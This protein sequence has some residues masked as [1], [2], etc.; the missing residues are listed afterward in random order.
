LNTLFAYSLSPS[1]ALG[2]LGLLLAL[3][4]A[5]L[6]F[7]L[8]L[9][10]GLSGDVRLAEGGRRSAWAVF[11]FTTLAVLVLEVA[12]VRNDFSLR[13]VADHSTTLTP[14]WVKLVTLWSALA[15]SVLFWA[16]VLSLY[17]FLL[18][19]VA[20]NDVLRPWVM[21]T[22]LFNLLFF[23]GI[24]LTAV[25][26]FTA[27]PL[28]PSQGAGPNPLL[29]NNAMMAV[30]PVLMYLGYVGLSVPFAYAVAA[31]ASG[32]LGESWLVQTRRW[33]L[34][35]WMFLSAAL[36]AGAFWSYEVLGWGGYWAWDPVENAAFFPWLFTTAYLHSLQIQERRRMLK[37]WNVWLIIAAYCSTLLGTFLTRSGVV[38]SVHS[39]AAGPS[40]PL[41]LVFFGVSTLGGVILASW[42]LSSLRDPR[43]IE[44]VLSR[45]SAFLAGNLVFVAFALMV[46]GGT[47]FPILV[48]VLTGAQSSVGAPFYDFFAI[49]LGLLLLALMGLGPLLPWNRQAKVWP[50]LRWPLAAFLA[51]LVLIWALGVHHL[52]PALTVGLA[53]FNLAGLIQLTSQAARQRG[54][55]AALPGLVR[56]YPRRYGAYLAHLGLVIVALG[57]AFSGSYQRQQ[58]ATISRGQTAQLLGTPV[59]FLGLSQRQDPQ[60]QSVVAH[61]VAG[62][63]AMNP[64][65]R[66]YGNAPTDPVATPE[67]YF[68]PVV[69]RY[70]TLLA[71]S[72]QGNWVTVRL[73][74]TPLVS[75]IWVGTLIL[76]LGTGTT[77][78]S[79]KAREL[80]SQAASHLAREGA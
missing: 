34:L 64:A 40:G 19:L 57:L 7:L 20:R 48:G 1:S 18:S 38:E 46:I 31:L 26:P 29:Q 39:F 67:V 78:I 52:G 27:M 33:T 49:P 71:Y 2:S 53:G 35:S 14:L 60:R 54:G 45:E 72:G 51:S 70:L 62:G 36:V 16:W 75:W 15:G 5:L 55:I 13:Y 76:L 17:T 22:M 43:R 24:N 28:P 61:L 65:I 3:G 69:D 6:G 12:T 50:A 59:R 8:S 56:S 9:G 23:L 10:G 25:N 44:G 42:R 74:K 41:F 30:H 4:F 68:R 80:S 66:V 77:L 63:E 11:L 79:G 58:T 37:A 21:A 73:I 32:R 47:L